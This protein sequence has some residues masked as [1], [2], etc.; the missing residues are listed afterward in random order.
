MKSMI[1]LLHKILHV[2]QQETATPVTA[3]DE[4]DE[5][6]D[7]GGTRAP[8]KSSVRHLPVPP[9]SFH[10]CSI[11]AAAVTARLRGPTTTMEAA[12]AASTWTA[13]SD[14]AG[15]DAFG[16]A[17]DDISRAKPTQF[18]A[19]DVAK[20]LAKL[21]AMVESGAM[22]RADFEHEKERFE[23]RLAERQQRQEQIRER[24]AKKQFALKAK[25]K[26]ERAARSKA[27]ARRVAAEQEEQRRA[28]YHRRQHAAAAAMDGLAEPLHAAQA[29]LE[30]PRRA[31]AAEARA[32]LRRAIPAARQGGRRD[33][34]LSSLRVLAQAEDRLG[35][36][37]IA[38]GVRAEAI[39]LQRRMPSLYANRN[40]DGLEVRDGV[41]VLQLRA[42]DRFLGHGVPEDVQ[43]NLPPG[44]AL[45]LAQNIPL[46]SSPPQRKPTAE[47]RREERRLRSI[48]GED[49]TKAMA[50]ELSRGKSKSRRR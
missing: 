33:I 22:S 44:S 10:G 29:L 8:R 17:A 15:I 30:Q 50:P 26:V 11:P 2:Y 1:G 18:D 6:E 9:P 3:T 27:E 31:A 32:L 34:E 47:R 13:L 40:R 45:A 7:G 48:Y 49:A 46:P 12:A 16:Y 21:E 36:H 37:A 23:R 25:A 39:G 20:A 28:A 41:P 4:A 14:A 35:N 42:L 38:D 19:E 43:R 5:A 24:E